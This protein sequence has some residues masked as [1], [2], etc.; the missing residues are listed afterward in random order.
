[1]KTKICTKCEKLMSI[2]EFQRRKD[3]GRL[4]SWCRGCVCTNIRS[5][6]DKKRVKAKELFGNKCCKCGYKKCINAL[7]FHHKDKTQKEFT[8]ARMFKSNSWDLIE[9]E[10]KKCI[11]VCSNCHREIH[12][13]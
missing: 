8:I 4:K 5:I 2:D 12:D 7:E 11:L 10:L 3:N 13:N 6:Q 9:I 1:M